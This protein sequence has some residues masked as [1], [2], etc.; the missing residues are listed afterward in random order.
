[1]KTSS[2][3]SFTTNIHYSYI[4]KLTFS[5]DGKKIPN[6]EA[7]LKLGFGITHLSLGNEKDTIDATENSSM[8]LDEFYKISDEVDM[9]SIFD[10]IFTVDDIR[11]NCNQIDL[12][13]TSEQDSDLWFNL[14]S[15][16]DSGFITDI[17]ENLLDDYGLHLLSVAVRK[18]VKDTYPHVC[19]IERD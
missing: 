2:K 11:T 1:M 18:T 4:V 19:P 3:K 16:K 9:T 17:T 10:I 5:A 15:T 7:L 14:H 12:L 6:S 8:D 13:V